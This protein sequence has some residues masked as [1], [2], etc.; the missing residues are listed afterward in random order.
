[1]NGSRNLACEH[2]FGPALG[3]EYA[4]V[5]VVLS[6]AIAGSRRPSR[7]PRACHGERA[8][9][10][11]QLFASRANIEVAFGI[12]EAKSLREKA[13]VRALYETCPSGS[14]YSSDPA[15]PRPPTTPTI[16]AEP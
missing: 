5:A 16:S 2:P 6:G 3:F 1:M 12:E 13:S 9:I 4:G 14:R 15:A 11:S 8:A 10:F 7:R